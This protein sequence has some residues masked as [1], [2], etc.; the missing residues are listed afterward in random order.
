MLR[1][2]MSCS[3]LVALACHA[4]DTGVVGAASTSGETGGETVG[5]TSGAS[6]SAASSSAG[7]SSGEPTSGASGV[8]VTT[9]E[10]DPTTGA[11]MS[12]GVVDIAGSCVDVAACGPGSTSFQALCDGPPALQC[13]VP[14]GPPCSVD[15]APGLCMSAAGCAAPFVATPGRCP[16]EADIQCCSDPATACDPD[17]A[18]RPNEGLA[19]LTW[20]PSCPPGMIGSDGFCIDRHEASLVEI[21]ARGQVVASWSPYVNPGS[22]RVRAVSLLGA[23]PQGY[24]SELQAAAACAEAGKRMCSDLEWLRACQGASAAIYPYGDAVMPGVCN[25]ARAVHPAVEYFGT[26]DPWIYGELDNACISQI[27]ASL[28]ITGQHPGC[29]SQDGALDMMGNLHEWTADPEGSFRGGFYVDTVLN[30]PGCLYKTTAHDVT[31]WDYSTG[32]RC[33]AD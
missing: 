26:A 3:L 25:D 2:G 31:Y 20:D 18:P 10:S 16:G 24:I 21:D 30:G 28:A 4:G 9:D 29:V 6:T 23:V 15:G 1:A 17:A 12:C 5:D 19:E 14:A 8:G 22:T 11:V 33:C 7:S 13:C 32:F 27:P